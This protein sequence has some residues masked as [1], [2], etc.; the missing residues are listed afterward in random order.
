[1]KSD[2]VKLLTYEYS[3]FDSLLTFPLAR[4]LVKCNGQKSMTN[5]SGERLI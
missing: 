3:Q 2:N 5:F 4:Q 1:M